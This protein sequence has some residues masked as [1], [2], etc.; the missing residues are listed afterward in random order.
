MTDSE[1]SDSR[2]LLLPPG[3]YR[4]SEALRLP[5]NWSRKRASE[6]LSRI[7]PEG[8]TGVLL[9]D[10]WNIV[11]F[12]GLWALTTERLLAAYLP[13]DGS[14][15]V[16]FYPWLDHELVTT[17]WF[18][19]GDCYFDVPDAAG[20]FPPH[21]RATAGA[22]QDTW[23]WL[24]E[25]MRARGL[26]PDGDAGVFRVDR[27]LPE[28]ARSASL[29]VFGSAPRSV[30]DTALGMRMVKTEEELA[31]WARAYS[32]FDD[33]HAY[34]RDR[35]LERDPSLTDSRLRLDMAGRV[36]DDIMA[37]YG[38]DR[39]PHGPVGINVDLGWVR[40]G[41]VTGYPHPNQVRHA[42]IADQRTVQV[43]GIIQVGGCGGELYRP[44]LLTTP[45]EYERRLWT[46]ARD[47]CLLLRDSLRAGRTGGEVAQDVHGFQRANGVERFAATRP[48]H[49]QG[50]EGHQPPY[51]SLG[52]QT[53][54]E[55]GMCFSA[56]PGL[57]DP[58]GGF[59][60]NFS[61][62]FVVQSQGPAVQL[63]RLPWTEE[64]CWLG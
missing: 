52:E 36:L 61:D 58:A 62:T 41:R 38:D 49:G 37:D 5:L 32:Y 51:I 11:T 25:R 29:R 33:V 47:S 4:P 45:S 30:G 23:E 50:M 12:T 19:D 56:E 54:L 63:S 7:D 27:E 35:I 9:L 6:L 28:A 48:S 1:M 43:S 22:A 14:A 57:Y 59:G 16:W 17:W 46:V 26:N 20:Q 15:P 10:P 21:G 42:V 44:Y 39:S 40:A 2:S 8:R 3:P 31:L 18:G 24:F 13:P 64:W 34:A 55:P 53:V 60:V